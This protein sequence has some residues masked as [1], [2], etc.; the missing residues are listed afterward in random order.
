VNGS[1]DTTS[2]GRSHDKDNMA[3]V[4]LDYIH[5]K[6]RTYFLAFMKQLLIQNK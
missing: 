6:D 2:S 1:E 5:N 4:S 3:D